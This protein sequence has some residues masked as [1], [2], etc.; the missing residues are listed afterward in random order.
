MKVH[1]RTVP[2]LALATAAFFLAPAKRLL[3]AEPDSVEL[4]GTW[5]WV[6][7]GIHPDGST[8]NECGCR[9]LL[10][11]KRTGEYQFIEQDSM[12]EYLL[13][14]GSFSTRQPGGMKMAQ[15][16]Q[17]EFWVTFRNWWISEERDQSLRLVGTDA[18]TLLAYSLGPGYG[19]PDN[20][21]HRFIRVETASVN[22]STTVRKVRRPLRDRPARWNEGQ[23][24][25]DGEFPYYEVA[26][27]PISHP[28]PVYP[29]FARKAQIQGQVILRVL[30][31][32]DG[33]VKNIKVVRGVTGLNAA[34]VN[35][36]KNWIYKP[37]LS[38]NKPVTVWIEVPVL[39]RL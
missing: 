18:D 28:G 14:E 12:N 7:G 24:P 22:G 11:L 32:K 31:G 17:R 3:A 35:A 30:V 5:R 10:T 2:F 38:D 34:A 36:V 23:L 21:F 13:C 19:A 33:R 15:G 20:D 26:P 1:F 9:R 27:I 39:F 25:P 6:G 8:P 16:T 37:A 4:C 29:D